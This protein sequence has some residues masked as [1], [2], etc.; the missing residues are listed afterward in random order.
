MKVCGCTLYWY[1]WYEICFTKSFSE[2]KRAC[3]WFVNDMLHNHCM[4]LFFILYSKCGICEAT[5]KSKELSM[6]KDFQSFYRFSQL[7]P[8]LY[9]INSK[10]CRPIFFH[11][12]SLQIRIS[13]SIILAL[14]TKSLK[15]KIHLASIEAW[16]ITLKYWTLIK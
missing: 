1:T 13:S 12:R 16:K 3:N 6:T 7:H 15:K 11:V 2:N 14:I 4:Y 8:N 10:W 5:K 9:H